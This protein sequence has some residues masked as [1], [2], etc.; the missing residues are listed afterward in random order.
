MTNGTE[1]KTREQRQ[2]GGIADKRWIAC[3]L[4]KKNGKH[5]S[6]TWKKVKSDF[7]VL[8]C[9]LKPIQEQLRPKF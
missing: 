2:K 9:N 1:Q 3:F 6:F 7:Y 4:N 8:S 5:C